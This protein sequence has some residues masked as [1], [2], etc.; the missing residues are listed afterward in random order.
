MERTREIGILK[1]LGFKGAQIMSMFLTE[2]GI[3]GV[4]GGILGTGLGFILAYGMGGSLNFGGG[5]RF[6]GGG[7]GAAT[8]SSPPIFSV[9][10]IIFSLS[11]PIVMSILAG[12]YP[13]W[14][15]SKMNIVNA[16]KYE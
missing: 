15:A 2:A 7:P 5:P 1:A 12:L 11:F 13:A 6:G 9:Q 4:V 8:P 16:L 14:R 10:L 3:T